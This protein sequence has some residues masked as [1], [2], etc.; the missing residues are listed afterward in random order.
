MSTS[1]LVVD[2]ERAFRVMA[3]E[4]LSAEG[5]EVR[6]AASLSRARTEVDRTSPD[7]VVLDRRLP[8]G[9]GIEFMSALRREGQHA[10][11]FIVVTAYGDIENAVE[12]LRAG[13]WDYLAKPIQLTDLVVKL[14]KIIETRRL[15]DRL[16]LARTSSATP[17]M[18][19]PRSPS[20]REVVEKLRSV[21]QA[22]TTPVLILGESGTGKQYAAELLHSM[23]TEVVDRDAPFVEVNCAALPENL[24]ESELFGHE[25]GAFTDA[26]TSR[27]GLIELADGGTLFLD[28]VTELPL[29]TQPKLLK[30]LDTMQFRRIG[31]ERQLSVQLRVVAATNRN[32]K[33]LVKA[34]RFREDLYHRLAVF[35]VAIPPLEKRPEDIPELAEAFVSFFAG[36]MKK[37]I[38]G[39]SPQAKSLLGTYRYRGNVRELR[40]IVE[41]AVILATG[42][43][44]QP[45][46]I[47]LPSSAET[48][49][50]GP[51]FFTVHLETGTPPPPLE[52]VERDYLLKVL[53]HLGGKRMAA[54][55]TLGISYPTFLKR[56]R[57][58][59][60]D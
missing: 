22:P 6:T 8:D 45:K 11:L 16:T 46:D 51:E 19:E 10:P 28:E 43:L 25:K 44:I 32:P 3:E 20:M 52:V 50:H 31:A 9:D 2:D 49:E 26:N 21:S 18:V 60:V 40:N 5:F 36:R 29:A 41:R 34:G 14:R 23:S 38:S 1:V 59:G 57:E 13:A 55:Q 24:V 35:E 4:A 47:V 39:L 17:P 54:A 33:E 53:T 48:E 7:I 12:A 56:L 15:R 58:L 27:R 42:S 37:S 30:F